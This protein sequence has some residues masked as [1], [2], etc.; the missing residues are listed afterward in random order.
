MRLRRI[1]QAIQA[2]LKDLSFQSS[3]E[4][5]K[6][7]FI[8][9]L[10]APGN[11]LILRGVITGELLKRVNRGQG[12]FGEMV[13]QFDDVL[14]EDKNAVKWRYAAHL[15]SAYEAYLKGELTTDPEKRYGQLPAQKK[16]V[17]QSEKTK[18]KLE[19][20]FAARKIPIV[21]KGFE[22]A[23]DF[24]GQRK[25]LKGT[26]GQITYLLYTF[27]DESPTPWI[28]THNLS[29]ALFETSFDTE[30]PEHQRRYTD[31]RRQILVDR[32]SHGSQILQALDKSGSQIT[33][34]SRDRLTTP[35]ERLHEV[36][37]QWVSRGQVK[38][39]PPNPQLEESI[40]ASFRSEVDA[41]VERGE[42]VA[43]HDFSF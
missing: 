31:E 36:F 3:P 18:E 8:D 1:A 17:F 4:M 14:A 29:H 9:M 22:W 28:I 16:K 2:V 11:E 40:E 27:Q 41:A 24:F 33:T 39:D 20:W 23:P 26:P 32:S 6:R 34:R 21:I 12:S 43:S 10:L 19:R 13:N 7:A 35:D 38:L 25:T 37:T 30:F 42:V 5:D 15:N